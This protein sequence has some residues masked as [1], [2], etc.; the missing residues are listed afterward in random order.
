MLILNPTTKGRL[1]QKQF[2]EIE[3]LGVLSQPEDLGVTVIHTSASFL[4]KKPKGDHRL[5]TSFVETNKYTKPSLP[6][7][8]FPGKVLLITAKWKYTLFLM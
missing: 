3:L 6:N 2:V 8:T 1:L 5:L 7:L 4:V